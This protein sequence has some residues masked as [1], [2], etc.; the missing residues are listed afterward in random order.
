[1]LRN[2][3]SRWNLWESSCVHYSGVSFC[4]SWRW[5]PGMRMEDRTFVWCLSLCGVHNWKFSTSFSFCK[6]IQSQADV[7]DNRN[8][9]YIPLSCWYGIRLKLSTKDCCFYHLMELIYSSHGESSLFSH[10]CTFTSIIP[11]Y[12]LL[13]LKHYCLHAD[14]QY[15]LLTRTDT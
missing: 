1:M 11:T 8:W 5:V 2:S 6:T 10:C 3:F 12:A 4:T 13:F 14:F 9:G 15:C 7:D